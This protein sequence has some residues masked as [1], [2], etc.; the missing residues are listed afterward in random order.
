MHYET[1]MFLLDKSNIK[2]LLFCIIFLWIC[3]KIQKPLCNA[4]FRWSCANKLFVVVSQRH[5]V[6]QLGVLCF[7]FILLCKIT[8]RGR[9]VAKLTNNWKATHLWSEKIEYGTAS[10]TLDYDNVLKMDD[11][12]LQHPAD[13]FTKNL[14]A[15]LA[16]L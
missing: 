9:Q 7:F 14:F 6:Y 10:I 15:K 11:E 8:A 2:T 13:R 5:I 1:F 4:W 16:P 3:N 12:F